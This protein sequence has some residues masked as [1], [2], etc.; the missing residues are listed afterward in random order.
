MNISNRENG[1]GTLK[2]SLLENLGQDGR[3]GK[4]Y[5][6]IIPQPHQNCN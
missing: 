1:A 2:K 4:Y 3:V 5:A 6:Q